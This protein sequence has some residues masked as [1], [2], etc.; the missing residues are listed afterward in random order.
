MFFDGFNVFFR[1]LAEI[2]FR[3]PINYIKKQVLD[4]KRAGPG[5]GPVRVGARSELG[6][7][8]AHMGPYGPLWAPYGPIWAPYGPIRAPYGPIWA[9]MGPYGPLWVLLDRSWQVR[10]CPISDFWS[11]FTCFGFK[12]CFLASRRSG[13][14]RRLRRSP[15]FNPYFV[16]RSRLDPKRLTFEN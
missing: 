16:K 6:P 2:R 5:W 7:L 14:S 13:M 10:T 9:L 11:N 4:P 8:W 12:I 1:F 3:T 15:E